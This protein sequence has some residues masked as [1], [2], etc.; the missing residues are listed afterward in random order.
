[1]KR[2]LLDTPLVTAVLNQRP[3]ATRLVQPW[4]TADEAAT[5]VF[6]YAEVYEFIRP[7][8]RFLRNYQALGELMLAVIPYAPTVPILERYADIRLALRR[9][10]MIGD[11]D[12]LI[13]AT[14]LAY[15]LTLVTIDPDFERVPG[16]TMIRLTPGQL[17]GTEPLPGRRP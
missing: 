12:T 16:L 11:I 13:A 7:S 14:A 3:G 2:Y 4:I 5:S 6:V 10:R 8:Q 17:R 9:G 1:V 15:E